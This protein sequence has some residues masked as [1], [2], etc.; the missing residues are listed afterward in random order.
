MSRLLGSAPWARQPQVV[1]DIDRAHPLAAR[2][3]FAYNGATVF[4]HAGRIQPTAPAGAAPMGGIP[5]SGERGKRQS[6]YPDPSYNLNFQQ[7]GMDSASITVFARFYVASAGTGFAFAF[8][9]EIYDRGFEVGMSATNLEIWMADAT[10]SWTNL[11]GPAYSAGDVID[12]AVVI[13]AGQAA[14]LYTSKN[15]TVFTS[16]GTWTNDNN[17]IA[18][19]FVIGAYNVDNFSS[20]DG[21]VTCALAWERALSAAEIRAVMAN[22][23]Q[24]FAPLRRAIAVPGQAAVTLQGSPGQW[25]KTLLIDGWFGEVAGI[26][27]WYAVDFMTPAAPGGMVLKAW[28]GSAWVT[29]TLKYWNGSAWV[30]KPLKRWN[31]SSWITA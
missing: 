16:A 29:G 8:E 18:S 24:V 19:E 1:T 5:R 14:K 20:L 30:A 15:G 21:I 27:G 31:G 2:L 9:D 22:P 12:A 7:R 25:D 28:N 4:D 3:A 10:T 26:K 17:L 23:W 6:G 11:T 13:R